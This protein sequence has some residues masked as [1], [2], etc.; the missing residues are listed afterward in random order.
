MTAYQL[1]LKKKNIVYLRAAAPEIV[2]LIQRNLPPGFFLRPPPKTPYLSFT[3][4]RKP[5]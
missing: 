2:P 1:E 3:V 4:T 5:V